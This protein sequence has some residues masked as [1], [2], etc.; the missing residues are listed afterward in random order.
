M[1]LD[2]V[3][4]WISQDCARV[5]GVEGIVDSLH[6]RAQ[7]QYRK[8]TETQSRETKGRDALGRSCHE[9]P[10]RVVGSMSTPS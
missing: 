2:G 8:Y 10:L 7:K 4:I 5:E 9:Q 3:C 6:S 1:H